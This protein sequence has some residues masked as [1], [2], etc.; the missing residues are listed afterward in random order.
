M[1][2]LFVAGDDGTMRALLHCAPNAAWAPFEIVDRRG[3]AA[4]ASG[5]DA[6]GRGD[7][8]VAGSVAAASDP[9]G[10]TSASFDLDVSVEAP[11]L[12]PGR[13]GRPELR[14]SVIDFPVVRYR[15]HVEIDGERLA[16]DAE[17]TASLHFGQRLVAY[18][19]LG[20]VADARRPTA[21]AIVLAAARGDDLPTGGALLGDVSVIYAFGRN[22]VPPVMLHAGTIDGPRIPLGWGTSIELSDARV[23]PHDLLGEPARTASVHATLI[24]PAPTLTDLAR[25]ETIDLGRVMIDCRGAAQTRLFPA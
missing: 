6:L 16:I 19:Y 13:L 14:M 12:G 4:R 25:T 18:V 11:G 20:T 8:W 7:G 23:V 10:I 5:K 1:L 2:R 3:V 15:G 24:R 22:G 9:R 21:P 17:G